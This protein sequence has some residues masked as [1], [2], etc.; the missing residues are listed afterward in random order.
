MA[1]TAH[2][3][4]VRADYVQ[5]QMADTGYSTHSAYQRRTLG[6]DQKMNV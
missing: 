3:A 1:F 6:Y 4:C 5:A 2:T